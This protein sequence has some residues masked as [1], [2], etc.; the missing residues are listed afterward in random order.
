MYLNESFSPPAGI[1]GILSTVTTP[2]VNSSWPKTSFVS[3]QSTN[4]SV[5]KVSSSYKP[6]S[7]RST[8]WLPNHQKQSCYLSSSHNNVHIELSTETAYLSAEVAFTYKCLSSATSFTQLGR[9]FASR[10]LGF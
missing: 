8:N 2:S 5:S 10:F 6:R 4:A 9:C 1:E 3:P 7:T